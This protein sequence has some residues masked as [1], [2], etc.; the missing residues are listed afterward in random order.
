MTARHE[1]KR[2]SAATY[3]YLLSVTPAGSSI[4]ICIGWARRSVA[5]PSTWEVGVLSSGDWT[6]VDA[7]GNRRDAERKLSELTGRTL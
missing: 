5:N 6:A 7:Y 1:V 2:T 3:L 4:K